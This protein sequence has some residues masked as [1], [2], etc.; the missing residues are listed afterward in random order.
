LGGGWKGGSGAAEANVHSPGL[1]GERR[2]LDEQ[3]GLVPQTQ[4]HQ[5]YR[6]QE[7][8]CKSR[9]TVLFAVITV[10]GS[11]DIIVFSTVAFYV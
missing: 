10:R 11:D 4:A 2:T 7:R 1:T 9:L 8:I 5:Q 3:T 6:R